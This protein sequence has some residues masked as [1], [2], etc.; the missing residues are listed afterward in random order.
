MSNGKVNYL[1]IALVEKGLLKMQHLADSDDKVGTVVHLL[2]PE[3]V[4]IRTALTR[5][6]LARREEEY[7]ARW[8]EI[9]VI[10]E[11]SMQL[12]EEIGLGPK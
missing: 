9:K 6:Y 1:I 12:P 7:E 11:R 8:G 10:R 2:T 4:K 3:G 5:D